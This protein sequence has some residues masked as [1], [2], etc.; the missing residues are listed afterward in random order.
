MTSDLGSFIPV[1]C[2]HITDFRLSN[3]SLSFCIR[4]SKY[5][6]YVRDASIELQGASY[7]QATSFN[8]FLHSNVHIMQITVH[9]TLRFTYLKVIWNVQLMLLRLPFTT[10]YLARYLLT[11]VQT[12]LNLKLQRRSICRK[13]LFT[14]YFSLFSK[15]ITILV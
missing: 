4:N 14:S 8:I 11:Y 6:A 5:T 2:L 15:P 7:T 9:Q 3:V 12:V 13:V 1:L 10:T